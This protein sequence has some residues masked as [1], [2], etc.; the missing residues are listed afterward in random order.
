MSSPESVIEQ[1]STAVQAGD[2]PLVNS[3]YS[4]L[5]SPR[6]SLDEIA[7]LAAKHAQPTVLEWCFQQGFTFPPDSLNDSF[8]HAA[9][10][11]RSPAIFQVLLNHGFDLNAHWS[12]Y[13][14]DGLV[15]AC[16][17]GNLP[18]ARLLLENG[19]DPNSGHWYGQYE[20]LVWAIVGDK[21]DQATKMDM[22]KLMLDHG[23]KLEETGAASAAAETENLELLELLL[24]R[25]GPELMEERAMWWG[26]T[27]QESS[28]SVGSPLYRACRAGKKDVVEFLLDRGANGRSKDKIGRSCLYVAKA[29]GHDDIVKL[30]RERGIEE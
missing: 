21:L 27:D 26:V 1:L 25:G 7:R 12:E 11:G 16:M 5:G 28:D 20:A 3:L 17:E 4:Q 24:E 8:F 19:Q 6:E 2:V 9:I 22:V 14:G 30:L 18:L 10:S 29:G 23:T 13:L 15:M